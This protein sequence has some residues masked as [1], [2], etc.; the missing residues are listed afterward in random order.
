MVLSCSGLGRGK[1]EFSPDGRGRGYL[2]RFEREVT[3]MKRNA[4]ALILALLVAVCCVTTAAAE[5]T[6]EGDAYLQLSD[7]YLWRGQN[8]NDNDA[9]FFVEGGIDLFIGDLSLGVWSIYD[10]G[11]KGVIETDYWVDYTFSLGDVASLT[12][13]NTY[14]ALEG[15]DAT[16]ELYALLGFETLL[17]P[18]LS[19]YYDWDEAEGAGMFY[20]FDIS[21]SFELHESLALN[22]GAIV[23][24]NQE[25]DYLIGDYND[26]HH[27]E[28]NASLDW[29]VTEQ[30]TVTPMVRASTGLSDAAKD[31]N[32][33]WY[34]LD[35]ETAVSIALTLTW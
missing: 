27:G 7:K 26:W 15:V 22:L 10:E 29:S 32:V 33:S 18:T 12:V 14:Y 20:T 24:Y 3:K 35:D 9:D 4:M 31:A 28:V 13:G 17:A 2:I 23:S 21:H 8:I 30:L 34:P 5:I 25:S 16:N 1:A 6:V 11:R 19:A